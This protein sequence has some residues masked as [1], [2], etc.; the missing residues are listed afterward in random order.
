MFCYDYKSEKEKER[1]VSIILK[2]RTKTENEL[3]YEM[4][5]Q[6]AL[7]SDKSTQRTIVSGNYVKAS[8]QN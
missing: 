5:F 6:I 3:I 4:L 8:Y 7:Y 2:V 1:P